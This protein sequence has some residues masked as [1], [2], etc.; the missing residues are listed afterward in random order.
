MISRSS[1]L[2]LGTRSGISAGAGPLFVSG[3]WGY[4]DAPAALTQKEWVI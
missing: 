3:G 1:P 4:L 2:F